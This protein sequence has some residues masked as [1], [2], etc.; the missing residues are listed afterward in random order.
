M[1]VTGRGKRTMDEESSDE[2]GTG[3]EVKTKVRQRIL[4]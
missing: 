3:L 1:E 2:R 4:S